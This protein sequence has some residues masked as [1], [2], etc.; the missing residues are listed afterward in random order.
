MP[1]PHNMYF[2]GLSMYSHLMQQKVI[3]FECFGLLGVQYPGH[4]HPHLPHPQHQ[5]HPHHIR[6]PHLQHHPGVN[7]LPSFH[8]QF[9][10]GDAVPPP[11]TQAPP[12]SPIPTSRY[13]GRV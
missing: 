7:H 9:P 8:S 2:L 3:I 5:Q 4:Q 6:H 1:P 11:N 12:A 10:F 13:G